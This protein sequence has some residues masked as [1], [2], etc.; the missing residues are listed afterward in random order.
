MHMTPH[1]GLLKNYQSFPK[2]KTIKGADK[3]TFNTLGIGHLK[4]T[5]QVGGKSID[6]QLMDMLHAPKITFTLISISWCDNAGYHTEF[7]HQ[8]CVIKSA[9]GKML[10]QAPKIYGLYCLDNKIAKIKSI[11]ALQL[12]KLIKD[13]GI[14][15]KSPET[16]IETWHDFRHRARL[17]RRQ[18]YLWCM[19]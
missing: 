8:K 5:T 1:Q 14:F 9:T 10:L 18:D 6:I 19:Y 13:S 11:H 15:Q 12:L 7:S 2:P 4:L 17:H 16:F 3:G